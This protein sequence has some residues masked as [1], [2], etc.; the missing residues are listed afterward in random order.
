MGWPKALKS[1][2]KETLPL[3]Q[4]KQ[5]ANLFKHVS[6]PTRLRILLMLAEREMHAREVCDELDVSQPVGRNHLALLRYGGVIDARPQGLRN[7]YTLT[8]KGE[9]LAGAIKEITG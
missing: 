4:V 7:F 1:G 9:M 5:A 3:Q 2:G 8:E 6:D